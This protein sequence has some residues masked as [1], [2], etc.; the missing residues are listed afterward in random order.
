MILLFS[1]ALILGCIGSQILPLQSVS[2]SLFFITHA[3]L[4]YIMIEVGLEFVINKKRWKE[5]LIDYGVASLAAALPWILCFAYFVLMGTNLWQ[6]DL[7]LARFAAP[8]ATGILFSMLGV[9]GLGATW[10]FRKIQVLAI[11]DDLDTILLLIPL[12]FLLSDGRSDL[13]LVGLMMIGCLYLGL[14][15]MHKVHLPI[16]RPFLLLY[17]FILTSFTL[18]MKNSF[19]IDIEV[20]LPAFV[21]GMM[22]KKQN[23][24]SHEKKFLEPAVPFSMLCDRAIKCLFMLLVGLLFPKIPLTLSVLKTLVIDTACIFVLMNLGKL[25]PLFFYKKEATFKERL[26]VSVGM[27]PRG[28]VGAGI[29]TLALSQGIDNPMVQVAALALALNLIL[30]GPFVSFITYLQKGK[31]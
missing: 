15:Y 22:L 27:M 23:H 7:L 31:P 13:I 28:E 6:E 4:A 29:L 2:P 11:L 21:F 8:T 3:I 12:Q 10:I 1:F 24:S 17:A 18:L 26:A 9:A 20:L 14:R 5:Y 16:T 30:T 19:S 25:T